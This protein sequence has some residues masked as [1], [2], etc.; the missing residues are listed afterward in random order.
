VWAISS[1][2]HVTSDEMM[3]MSAMYGNITL[4]LFFI[5]LAQCPQVDMSLQSDK[6]HLY[7]DLEPISHFLS[8][9][10]ALLCCR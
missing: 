8:L 7:T 6:L 5:M 10:N 9:L 2:E 3:T 1:Q 4:S